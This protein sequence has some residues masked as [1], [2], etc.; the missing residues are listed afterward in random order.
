MRG[1]TRASHGQSTACSLRA[2]EL[3]DEGE[4]VRGCGVDCVSAA[5]MHRARVRDRLRDGLRCEAELDG[6]VLRCHDERGRSNLVE[7]AGVHAL[8]ATDLRQKCPSVGR[9][10]LSELLGQLVPGSEDRAEKLLADR[11][12]PALGR[13]VLQPLP[14]VLE[15]DVVL[16]G[17]P[18]RA[19]F[20]ERQPENRVRMPNCEVER[21]RSPVAAADHDRRSSFQ[22][23]KE[24]ERVIRVLL[25]GGDL[26]QVR[27]AHSACSRDG[28]R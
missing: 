17:K 9:E 14:Q 1:A 4:R 5:D 23:A 22:L 19:C 8:A 11:V 6:R 7:A 26:V 21:H 27:E 28:R 10:D 15:P 12:D 25:D 18:D 2:K 20:E 3:G 24:L 16:R 13:G